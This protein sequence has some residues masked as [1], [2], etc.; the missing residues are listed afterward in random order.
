MTNP[1]TLIPPP[2]RRIFHPPRPAAPGVNPWY[3]RATSIAEWPL[4]SGRPCRIYDV[5]ATLGLEGF[6]LP[7]SMG[8]LSGAQR[9][10]QPNLPCLGIT[11]Q[12][13][14]DA[15]QWRYPLAFGMHEPR[16]G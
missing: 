2:A 6:F 8:R 4:A 3:T 13:H 15:C 1:Q 16:P 5:T 11:N 14:R 7:G 10:G 12:V 9:A